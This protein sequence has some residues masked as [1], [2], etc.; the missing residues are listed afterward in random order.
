MKKIITV[1]MAAML[2][3]ALSA[4]GEKKE[5]AVETTAHVHDY[6]SE[7]Y[8]L[9]SC[10]EEGMVHYSCHCGMNHSEKMDPL[11]HQWG[12][13]ELTLE[14]THTEKGEETRT[15]SECEKTETREVAQLPTE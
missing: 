14:P 12:Q 6:I 9:P 7:V 4:C 11:G 5:D 10:E 15:C 8:V 13:W 2:V 1:L 3:F